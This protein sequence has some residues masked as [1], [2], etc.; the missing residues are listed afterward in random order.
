[1]TR[2][3]TPASATSRFVPAPSR[4]Y[5]ISRSAQPAIVRSIASTRPDSTKNSAGP[6]MPNDVREARGS[7]WLTPGRARSQSRLDFLRQLIAQLLANVT[8][9]H[10]QEHVVRSN[11]VLE[12]L[13]RVLEAADVRAVGQPVGEVARADA[14][15]VLLA[16]GIDVEQQ[17]AVGAVERAREVVDEGGQPRVAMRL[18]DHDQPAVPQLP[19]RLDGGAHLGGVMAVVVVNGGALK[20]AQQ[21]EPAVRAGETLERGGDLLEMDADLQ[22]HGGC[23]GGVLDVVPAALAQ[24]DAADRTAPV[25]DG[26]RARLVA[27]VVGALVG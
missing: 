6:P 1:M 8:G 24:V 14:S 9:S 13:A 4:R 15:R 7:S 23:A 25:M 17:H 27:A 26:E 3:S 18:E 5:G 16:R 10:Q 22:R 21:L 20:Q 19:R 11:Q 12:R 2:P